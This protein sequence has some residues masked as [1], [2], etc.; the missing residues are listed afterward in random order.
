MKL[1]EA[2]KK[3]I[4]EKRKN[5]AKMED[6]AEEYG[7]HRTAINAVL[8]NAGIYTRNRPVHTAKGGKSCPQC[9]RGPFP[10]EFIFC[11]YCAADIRT[12]RE[13][14]AGLL[15]RAIASMHAPFSEAESKICFAMRKALDFVNNHEE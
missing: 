9:H 15:D 4:I 13:I 5:G 6:L 10:A 14:V 3:E 8:N 2:M 12:E 11:P 7:V 1:T